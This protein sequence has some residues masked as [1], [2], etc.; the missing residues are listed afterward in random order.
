MRKAGK[1]FIAAAFLT[2]GLA[3]PAAA[4]T[5][6][7]DN[8][9]VSTAGAK[10]E[11]HAYGLRNPFRWS[12]DRLT[13]DILIGDV[14][15]G[16][17]EEIDYRPASQLAG[18][19]FGWDCWEGT[20]AGPGPCNPVPPNTP[21]AYEYPHTSA[22]ILWAVTGGVVARDPGL[23]A[24]NGR[25]L[26]T[27]FYA[28][29]VQ[30]LP[31]PP[32]GSPAPTGLPAVS[33]VVA[34]GQDAVG[35]VYVVSLDGQVNRLTS[36]TTSVPVG[37]SF[38]APMYAA[39]PP[40]DPHRL[41][42]V[43]RAGR[44][45]LMVDDGAPTTFLDISSQVSTAGEQG[46]STIAFPPDYAASGLFYVYFS[47]RA[48]NIHVDQFRRSAANPNAADPGSQQNVL[49]IPHPGETNHYGGQLNF[50]GDGYLYVSTGDGGNANDPNGNA[51]NLG[52]LLGKLLRIDVRPAG[53][54][55][56]TVQT[57]DR[58]P[59]RVQLS[60]RHR[61]HIGKPRS[62]VVSARANES[63]TGG[64]Y[65][66]VSV[67]RARAGRTVRSRTATVRLPANARKRVRIFFSGKVLR[68]LRA[69]VRK[70][71]R[72]VARVRL[73]VRDAAGNQSVWRKNVRL[74]R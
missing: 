60:A 32:T 64:A 1:L 59:P 61:Q 25:Y 45:K 22:Q 49:V 12:F 51:Q 14:G 68:V 69:E 48:G 66:L 43:E 47:D 28:S 8:P 37:P 40:N 72:T 58:V 30:S 65:S 56:G 23:G 26:F 63:A 29:Q 13:G 27:D 9:F 55:N 41:F 71:H 44:V 17:R 7:P 50:G 36:A 4:Y 73:T 67:K 24:L 10:P 20:V 54:G 16:A 3:A 38:S 57:Q 74:V 70:R 11:I 31:F 62:I 35:H 42:V 21:P 2:L 34:F 53:P 15:E 6:P 33:H 5:V 18:T 39:A 19:N 46:L 52:S